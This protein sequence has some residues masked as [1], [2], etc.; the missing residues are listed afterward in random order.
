M[1]FHSNLAKDTTKKQTL[2]Y[3][4]KQTALSAN[5]FSWKGHTFLGWSEH[6]DGEVDFTNKQLV[7]NLTDQKT[8]DLY[9]VW[10]THTYTVVFEGNGADSGEMGSLDMTYGEPAGLSQNAFRREGYTFTGWA[11]SAKGTA[12]Y[13]D[14]AEVTNLTDK[15]GAV[16]R[17]YA[18]W[19]KGYVV[20]FAKGAENVT[21]T[22]KPMKMAAG[23]TYTLT[24]VTF[25]Q[26]GYAFAGWALEGSDTVYGNRAKV[27]DLAQTGIVTLTAQWNPVTY[28]V[29][30][31]AN[32]GTGKMAD[33][34][35][36][37]DAAEALPQNV[38]QRSGK[39]F[40]GWS[41]KKNGTLV[42]EDGAAVRNLA[43][44][45]GKIVTLYA[46]WGTVQ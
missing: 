21:G 29:R 8:I 30:F 2:T 16:V 31:N 35:L 22:M 3:D 17:L 36:T 38:F 33:A 13:G 32:G 42:Y 6:K 26:P 41:T 44:T 19:F 25:K 27:K 18:T 1:V 28:K 9:A 46:V 24:G 4:G 40:L 15:D 7:T 20:A 14:A 11:A 12:K 10:K 39:V 23:K 34:V 5:S 37:Y 45:Q 43:N